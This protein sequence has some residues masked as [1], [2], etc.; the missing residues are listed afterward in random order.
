MLDPAQFLTSVAKRFGSALS[1]RWLQQLGLTI[2]S[3]GMRP[4]N[5]VAVDA[6]DKVEPRLDRNVCVAVS[7]HLKA[8][9]ALLAGLLRLWVGVE[10]GYEAIQ[11]A[12]H[13]HG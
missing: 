9:R 2:C 7:Q 11:R 12:E 1:W 3:A 10:A 13:T 4:Y 6:D 8:V 5:V